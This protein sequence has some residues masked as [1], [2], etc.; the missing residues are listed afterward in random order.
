MYFNNKRQL[1]IL[2]K[3]RPPKQNKN[4]SISILFSDMKLQNISLCTGN[5]HKLWFSFN[6][7]AN[8]SFWCPVW[9]KF[10][11]GLFTVCTWN[12]EIIDIKEHE[13]FYRRSCNCGIYNE[14][15]ITVTWFA[16]VRNL[17]AYATMNHV[18]AFSPYSTKKTLLQRIFKFPG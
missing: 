6:L 15:Y 13:K 2:R 14:T 9:M 12:S 7:V 11:H 18:K 17:Y 3:F 8:V 4:H 5:K 10:S 16:Y 1:N